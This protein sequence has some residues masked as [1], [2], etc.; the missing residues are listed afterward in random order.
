MRER[1]AEVVE[2]GGGPYGQLIMARD[3]R[4]EAVATSSLKCL[5]DLLHPEVTVA[6]TQRAHLLAL[7]L[8]RR[9]RRRA[10]RF[11]R[12]RSRGPGLRPAPTALLPPASLSCRHHPFEP[13]PTGMVRNSASASSFWQLRTRAAVRPVRCVRT[14]SA[15]APPARMRPR[16]SGQ[17]RTPP[18]S[19]SCGKCPA[20]GWQLLRSRP[21]APGF[22]SIHR[23]AGLHFL[24]V[25]QGIEPPP[26]RRGGIDL[27]QGQHRGL[28]RPSR[29]REVVLADRGHLRDWR[30]PRCCIPRRAE[31]ATMMVRPW[32]WPTA[33]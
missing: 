20:R 17:S 1:I 8:A 26:A 21:G 16:A 18:M 7:V 3:R 11:A 31:R 12:G 6:R 28:R 23:P 9:W 19:A 25:A 22:P 15:T 2:T 24:A 29:V 5:G 33:R 30:R 14:L 10:R 13:T 27:R 32:T 4:P